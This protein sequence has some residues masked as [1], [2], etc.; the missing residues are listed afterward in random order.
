MIIKQR[1]SRWGWGKGARGARH[2][3]RNS[4]K[5]ATNTGR[6]TREYRRL[7]ECDPLVA[8]NTAMSSRVNCRHQPRIQAPR[9]PHPQ[10]H[11]TTHTHTHTHTHSRTTHRDNSHHRNVLAVHPKVLGAGQDAQVPEAERKEEQ[12]GQLDGHGAGPGEQQVEPAVGLFEESQAEDDEDRKR[13]GGAERPM[14][15]VA[16]ALHA[17]GVCELQAAV[18]GE[19]VLQQGLTQ[20]V[21]VVGAG[22]G[23]LVG[24]GG[25]GGRALAWAHAALAA[26]RHRLAAA[27][28][29]AAA[30][31]PR[32]HGRCRGV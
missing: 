4:L 11:I 10:T 20:E 18:A 5:L 19:G 2:T 7:K 25:G 31:V 21:G 3:C 22:R 23:H 17:G 24:A 30:A 16:V 29:A 6:S 14:P 27:A 32:R 9:T 1:P 13:E 15:V 26:M 12:A 8:M 28:A